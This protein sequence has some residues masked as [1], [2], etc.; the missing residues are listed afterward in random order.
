MCRTVALEMTARYTHVATNLLRAVTSPLDRLLPPPVLGSRFQNLPSWNAVL[1]IH[2]PMA[3]R[4][5]NIRGSRRGKGRSKGL[6]VGDARSNQ[7]LVI[8]VAYPVA[9]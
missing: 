7:N 8:A 9:C 6:T 1:A 2:N 4:L 5:G 3:L